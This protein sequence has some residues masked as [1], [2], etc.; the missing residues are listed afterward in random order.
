MKKATGTGKMRRR[1]LTLDLLLV[2]ILLSGAY[3]RLT[4]IDWGEYQY[5]H[6]DERFLVGVGTDITPVKCIDDTIPSN[7][8][9]PEQK[10]WMSWGEYFDTAKSTMNPHNQGHRFYVYGTLPL[11]MVRYA[12]E[13]LYG[14]SGFDVMTDVG[15]AFSAMMD[16]LTVLLVYLIASWVYDRRI[17]ILAAAFSALAAMQIQLSHFFAVDTFLNFFTWLAIYFAVRIAGENWAINPPESSEDSGGENVADGDDSGRLTTSRST[18]NSSYRR[19]ISTFIKHPYFRLSIAF[20][21]AAGCAVASKLNAVAVMIML[22]AAFALTFTTLS[23]SDRKRRLVD[24]LAYLVLAAAVSIIVF[25]LFQPYAFSG[26]GLLGVRLNSQWVDNIL[27]QLNR[28]GGDVDYP[29][30]LQ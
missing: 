22:P 13:W 27:E 23:T 1:I 21:F 15:R 3:F 18:T 28:A 30:M 24:A 4:G 5:L 19:H 12:V 9:P 11:F 6:P 2:I 10:A 26:P 14:H 17:A 8:C 16:L 25:R 20:G 29:P 7:A